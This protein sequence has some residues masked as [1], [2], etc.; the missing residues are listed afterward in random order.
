[1]SKTTLPTSLA[2]LAA[3][4]LAACAQTPPAAPAKSASSARAAATARDASAE[5]AVPRY[6]AATFFETESIAGA[7]FSADEQRVLYSSDRSGVF[8]VYAQPIA[9]GEPK[10]LTR[11]TTNATTLVTP[12]PEDDRVIVT[13]DVG[14]NELNHLYVLEADGSLKDVTP[15]EKLK[16]V[17]VKF[18][19]D[20]ESF[21]AVTNERDP[22]FFDL[23]RYSAKGPDYARELVF[24]NDDSYNIS[25]VTTDGRWV[26]LGKSRNNADSD[27]FVWDSKTPDAPP[28]RLTPHEGDALFMTADVTP[29]NRTLVVLS[30]EGGEFMRAWSYDLATGE[31]AP[32]ASAPW[33]IV[34]VAYSEDGRYRATW[35][36]AD[37]HTEVSLV[38][39]ASGKPVELPS[40]PRG[41]IRGVTFSR[42]GK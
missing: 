28:R 2:L 15:G 18:S 33:D 14:G 9:G 5:R 23:Y 27:I 17:F 31:R 39:T 41:Q 29:D 4:L 25:E 32:L 34:G 30:D 12:F 6:D 42:S 13:A 35:I 40:V 3:A 20:H 7:G 1:M 38:E 24:K 26:A 19:K 11:S 8:N 22:R 36:N 37:G 10:A 21:F 16:A